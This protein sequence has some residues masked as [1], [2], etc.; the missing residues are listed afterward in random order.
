MPNVWILDDL[1]LVIFDP[2]CFGIFYDYVV[3]VHPNLI[4]D[5]EEL[6]IITLYKCDE[7]K[8]SCDRLLRIKGRTKTEEYG[9]GMIEEF[10]YHIDNLKPAFEKYKQTKSYGTL[11]DKLNE[12]EDITSKLY[13]SKG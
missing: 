3:A 11:V 12:Y 6:V 4:E 9:K 2:Y 7:N 1:E 8:T 10:R 13:R 5:I